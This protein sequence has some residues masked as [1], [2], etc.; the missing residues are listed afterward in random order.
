MVIP[1]QNLIALQYIKSK[2]Q[3]LLTVSGDQ[4]SSG[5]DLGPAPQSPIKLA[6]D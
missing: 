5:V 1:C 6:L 2:C 4:I 3:S